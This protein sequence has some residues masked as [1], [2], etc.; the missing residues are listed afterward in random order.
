[1]TE[2]R[3]PMF[4]LSEN[5][6]SEVHLSASIDDAVCSDICFAIFQLCFPFFFVS[7]A[8]VIELFDIAYIY[9]RSS[10][11][12][13]YYHPLVYY[14]CYHYGLLSSLLLHIYIYIYRFISYISLFMYMYALFYIDKYT[15]SSV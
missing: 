13:S 11:L 7:V 8:H 4:N 12:F 10:S 9:L 14:Y 1:M 6:W 15:I 3:L 5:Y 2:S